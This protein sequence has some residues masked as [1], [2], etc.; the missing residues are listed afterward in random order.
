[1]AKRE[2]AYGVNASIFGDE[3]SRSLVGVD[4]R[5][6]GV[7]SFVNPNGDEHYVYPTANAGQ[8]QLSAG[9]RTQMMAGAE[10]TNLVPA[11]VNIG[12]ILDRRPPGITIFG[13]DD[14]IS[15]LLCL[16]ARGFRGGLGLTTGAVEVPIDSHVLIL[17]FTD[18]HVPTI[19]TPDQWMAGTGGTALG[20]ALTGPFSKY[21]E[22][23]AGM[24]N[25]TGPLVVAGL[26]GKPSGLGMGIGGLNS[27]MIAWM[28][29]DGLT[30]KAGSPQEWAAL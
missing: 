15:Q 28:A 9:N 8:Y 21:D 12:P 29:A 25:L 5:Y 7:L 17:Y 6:G 16:G 3:N 4:S 30:M 10:G 14:R 27:A 20:A 1:M 26:I 2:S 23:R 11:P 22:T 19:G 18:G 13:S 24:T